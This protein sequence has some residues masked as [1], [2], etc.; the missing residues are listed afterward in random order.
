MD[1]TI[2][3]YARGIHIRHA[4]FYSAVPTDP[5]QIARL[6][7]WTLS[8]AQGGGGKA[9]VE[10][11]APRDRTMQFTLHK[12]TGLVHQLANE[13]G[14]VFQEPNEVIMIIGNEHGPVRMTF[15][16][17]K[18]PHQISERLMDVLCAMEE[19]LEK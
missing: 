10:G 3:P 15:K 1:V 16:N 19:Y 9:F 18:I 4:L 2:E 7:F 12:E 14:W 11:T 5:V 17:D 8:Q 6:N 13:H